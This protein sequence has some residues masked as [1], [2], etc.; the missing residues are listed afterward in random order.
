LC[1][2]SF[3][4]SAASR[5]DGYGPTL[6]ADEGYAAAMRRRGLAPHAVWSQENPG[7][8]RAAMSELL[9]REPGLTAVITMNEIA[10]FGAM[11]ELQV[12]GRQIPRD[13]SILSIVSSPGV[14]AM[15]NPALTTMASPGAD[16]GRARR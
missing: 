5:A 16:L 2:A 12:R 4:F 6:R 1:A 15:S 3:A 14:A 10:T 9:A 13:F 11:V 7:A 8:G